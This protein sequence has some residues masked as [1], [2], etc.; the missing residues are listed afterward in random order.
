MQIKWYLK[1]KNEYKYK[2]V[3]VLELDGNFECIFIINTEYSLLH[4][5]ILLRI[6]VKKIKKTKQ[7]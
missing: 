1:T 6:E 5:S 2:Y 4:D 7:K 3:L